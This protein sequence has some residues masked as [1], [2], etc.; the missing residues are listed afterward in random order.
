MIFWIWLQQALGY[1]NSKIRAITALFKNLEDFYNLID[2]EGDSQIPQ[3]T[4]YKN[5]TGNYSCEI[6]LNNPIFAAYWAIR[7]S[8]GILTSTN[9]NIALTYFTVQTGN[10]NFILEGVMSFTYSDVNISKNIIS[11]SIQAFISN[12]KLYI[13]GLK[14]GEQ[15]NVYTIS[16]VLVYQGV[17]AQEEET[18][19]LTG[20]QSIYVVISGKRTVK[21]IAQTK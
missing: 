12:E 13:S 4:L 2:F 21:V 9:N 20:T 6:T 19:D 15:F 14:F 8:N 3:L 16:G 1:G 18:V 17:A 5:E 11:N 10:P 7:Y